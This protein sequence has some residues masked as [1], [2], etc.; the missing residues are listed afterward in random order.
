VTW[1]ANWLEPAS[2]RAYQDWTQQIA[3]DLVGRTLKPHRFT[4]VVP[5][6]VVVIGERMPDGT[7]R[8]FFAD[9]NRIADSRR[10]YTADRAIISGTEEGIYLNLKDGTLQ[11]QDAGGFREVQFNAYELSLEGL[12]DVG[13]AAAGLLELDTP[14][15]LAQ[16]GRDGQWSQVVRDEVNARLAETIRVAGLC[17]FMAALMAFPNARRS[18]F[19]MPM[20]VVVLGV[21]LVDRVVSPGLLAG[22]TPIG[23]ALGPLLLTFAGIAIVVWRAYGHL[24]ARQPA[25]V[26]A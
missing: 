10:T 18:R 3:A 21:T 7:V 25:A 22:L 17:V 9:D 26:P 13:G 6:F 16:T 1:V 5:N 23:Q 12:T 11:L 20:E 14:D 24:P 8:N 4:E 15:L 19:H 2:R